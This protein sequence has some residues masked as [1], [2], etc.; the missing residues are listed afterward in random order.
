MEGTE[1]SG[2]QL[3]SISIVL[4]KPEIKIFISMLESLRVAVEKLSEERYKVL[5]VV[6]DNSVE[7]SGDNI[8]RLIQNVWLLP[9]SFIQ[10]TENGGFAKAHN[11]AINN[12]GDSEYHL[13]LNPD[14]ILDSNALVLALVYL[15]KHPQAVLVTPFACSEDGSRQYLCK[16]YPSVFDL[17]LRGFAPLWCQQFFI[18]RLADYELKGQTEE[19]ELVSV[20]IVSGC[21]MLLRRKNFA[22]V[23]GFSENFFLYFEDF[24][25]SIKLRQIGNLAYVP[26]VKI[27]HFGG[28]AAKKGVRHI[29]LFV[30][31]MVTFFN[32][33]GWRW[34]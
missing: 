7:P 17:F 30:R 34:F 29:F 6:I 3:I 23:G 26:D 5:L 10:A 24:D 15:Q 4:Y 12:V 27:V 18:R 9:F 28:Q 33:H 19:S 2:H 25:L 1:K 14:V 16:S 31:S 22:E 20:P 8:E 11:K 32:K 13:I 21:F